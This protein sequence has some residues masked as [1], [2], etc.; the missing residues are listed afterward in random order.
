ME[1][2]LYLLDDQARIRFVQIDLDKYGNLWQDFYDGYLA[3][4]AKDEDTISID[5]LE[6]VL[7]NK[8]LLSELPDQNQ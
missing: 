1:G 7:R 3:E 6:K 8:G 4:Q 2:I 5:D